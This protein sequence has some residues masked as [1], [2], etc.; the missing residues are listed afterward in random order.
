MGPL[1]DS[2]ANYGEIPAV[3]NPMWKQVTDAFLTEM[4]SQQLKNMTGQ[5]MDPSLYLAKML[6]GPIDSSYDTKDERAR[7]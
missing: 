3:Y 7:R 6:L 5:D 2:T 4:E 1:I